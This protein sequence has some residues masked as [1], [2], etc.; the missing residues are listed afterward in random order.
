M[1]Q[2]SNFWKNI[3]LVMMSVIFTLFIAEITLRITIPHTHYFSSIPN[4]EL[5]RTNKFYK[6]FNIDSSYRYSVN[7]FGY[8]SASLFSKEKYGILTIG[9]STTDCIGL[10]DD[11]TW[12]WLLEEKL[13]YSNKKKPFTVGNIGVPAFNSFHHVL[14]VE[15]IVPQ[16]EN[17]RM[18]ILLVG[19][20]DFSRF[21]H[22]NKEELIPKKEELLHQAFVRHPRKVNEGSFQKT[23][24]YC[25][26][27]DFANHLRIVYEVNNKDFDLYKNLEE[28]NLAFKSDSL[29]NLEYGIKIMID[30]VL[31]I[32]N[33][34]DNNNIELIVVTQPVLWHKDMTKE[35]IRVSSYGKSIK[36][37]KTYSDEAM[38]KGMAIF[39]EAILKKASQNNINAID[40][41]E[42]FPKSNSVFFDHCHYNKNGSELVS[43]I[44]FD[45]LK[46]VLK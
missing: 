9:G 44:I 42:R 1:R 46:D 12:P 20:N 27:R 39:N 23:E 31:K 2:S 38:A 36:N 22:L 40:L 15:K 29:P 28:Y 35:E 13:N 41:A 5:D 19:F 33:Y 24:L 7:R 30:N 43:E 25:Y 45:Q 32:N 3:L 21:L 11:E 26:L 34:C 16:F 37:G 4:V 17:I 14:Q 18:V 6:Y 10:A 8:R